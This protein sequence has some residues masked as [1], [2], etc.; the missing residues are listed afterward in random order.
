M[1]EILLYLL[2]IPRDDGDL[3]LCLF[4]RGIIE[5]LGLLGRGLLCYRVQIC[6][7]DGWMA[8]RRAD[9]KER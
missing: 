3:V 6:L 1:V 4:R 5:F 7:M 8:V 2:V 9:L